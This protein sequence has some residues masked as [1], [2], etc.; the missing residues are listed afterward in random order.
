M[1]TVLLVLILIA[2][3]NVW[4][5]SAD[6]FQRIQ[7]A[8]PSPNVNAW[9]VKIGGDKYL[10]TPA[11]V[12][13]FSKDQKWRFSHFLDDLKDLHWK[14]PFSYAVKPSPQYDICWAKLPSDDT[15]NALSLD[16]TPIMAPTKVNVLFRQPYNMEGKWVG[17]QST[18]GSTE[19]TLYE[20]PNTRD[21]TTDQLAIA[22]DFSDDSIPLAESI[23]IGFRG[24]SGAIAL[25]ENGHCRGMF[26]KRGNLIPLKKEV[27]SMQKFNFF[28]RTFMPAVCAR[29]DYLV[30]TTLTRDDLH[31]LGVVFDARRGIFLTAAAMAS[32][33]RILPLNVHDIIGQ[34]A[35]D[36][37]RF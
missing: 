24:M 28:E 3:G 1:I 14:I 23:D 34:T 32:I 6:L 16:I 35:P 12:A 4:A 2:L 21:I 7:S 22:G 9:R 8:C 29:L 15:S 20:T 26:V 33:D 13:I 5:L 17:S 18:L 27:S 10:I 30:E 25:S 37:P 11:H 36:I 31:E 19:A